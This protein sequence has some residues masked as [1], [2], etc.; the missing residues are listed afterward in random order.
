MADT[1]R[2]AYDAWPERLYIIDAGKVVYKGDPGP[3]GYDLGEVEAWLQQ[4]FA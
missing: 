3:Y 1:A 2:L 4:R